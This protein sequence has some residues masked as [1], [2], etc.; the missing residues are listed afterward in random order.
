MRVKVKDF[1]RDEYVDSCDQNG[2][3][4]VYDIR[5]NKHTTKIEFL[6]YNKFFN[7]WDYVPSNRFCPVGD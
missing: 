6:I 7:V 4:E 3:I 2:T 1:Y 5:Y